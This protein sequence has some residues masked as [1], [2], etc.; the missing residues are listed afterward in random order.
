MKPL[1]TQMFLKDNGIT[2]K[3]RCPFNPFF[4]FQMII[5]CSNKHKRT[6]RDGY[7]S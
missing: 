4:A 2:Q 6:D 1:F 5:A 7:Y 3:I